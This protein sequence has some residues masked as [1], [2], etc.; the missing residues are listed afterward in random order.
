MESIQSAACRILNPN[1]LTT[2]FRAIGLQILVLLPIVP[3]ESLDEYPL[4]HL[5]NKSGKFSPDFIPP[6]SWLGNCRC[7]LCWIIQPGI[8][9]PESMPISGD[10]GTGRCVCL[11][12][13]VGRVGSHGM[14]RTVIVRCLIRRNVD[15]IYSIFVGYHRRGRCSN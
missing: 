14:T 7:G 11:A 6:G 1:A 3:Q 8:E 15:A 5:F 9:V 10:G 2:W 4:N 12:V 13:S